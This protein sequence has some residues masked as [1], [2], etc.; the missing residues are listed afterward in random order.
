EI[1]RPFGHA[2]H[3]LLHALA[4]AA[5]GFLGSALHAGGELLGFL[6][7]LSGGLTGTRR[8]LLGRFL[9]ALLLFGVGRRTRWVARGHP[10]MPAAFTFPCH[11]LPPS[12]SCFGPRSTRR[13]G[14]TIMR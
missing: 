7:H 13:S 12:R 9:P 4:G 11:D 14:A 5:P 10:R 2:R 1:P 6:L 8:H 3:A